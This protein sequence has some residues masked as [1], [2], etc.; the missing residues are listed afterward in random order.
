MDLTVC[1]GLGLRFIRIPF[2]NPILQQRVPVVWGLRTL[3]VLVF[4][5]APFKN[6]EP[7]EMSMTWKPDRR[8]TFFRPPAYQCAVIYIYSSPSLYTRYTATFCFS[9][10]WRC[11]GFGDIS[12]CTYYVLQLGLY[13]VCASNKHQRSTSPL[14]RIVIHIHVLS[15]ECVNWFTFNKMYNWNILK[16]DYSDV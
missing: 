7:Y 3:P 4:E 6:W 11:K 8:S 9:N 1:R 12:R 14:F 2:S 10:F 16:C 5:F 15:N 13:I